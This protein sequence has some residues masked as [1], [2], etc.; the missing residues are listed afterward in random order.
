MFRSRF[1]CD[2][3]VDRLLSACRVRPTFLAGYPRT[4]R[5]KT[6]SR[7]RAATPASGTRSFCILFV[8]LHTMR[9]VQHVHARN[10]VRCG[11]ASRWLGDR[12]LIHPPPIPGSAS[13]G[14][15]N[16][17]QGRLR[18][19][20]RQGPDHSLR[21]RR[22]FREHASLASTLLEQAARSR[23]ASQNCCPLFLSGPQDDLRLSV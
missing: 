15:T 13:E 3:S 14:I 2:R 23:T 5:I 21:S 9:R 1:C 20:Q 19:R 17:D 12:P 7:L 6:T 22:T 8:F 11:E 16:R 18:K 4:S 10:C